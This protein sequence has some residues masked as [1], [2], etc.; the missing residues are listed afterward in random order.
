MPAIGCQLCCVAV[1]HMRAAG[2]W[3]QAWHT[4]SVLPA[5]S[6]AV[7]CLALLL[8]LSCCNTQSSVF[9]NFIIEKDPVDEASVELPCTSLH[10]L[11]T[12]RLY[13]IDVS[14]EGVTDDTTH[15]PFPSLT[16]LKAYESQYVNPYLHML[17]SLKQLSLSRHRLP[18]RQPYEDGHSTHTADTPARGVDR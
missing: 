12:L 9:S 6:N 4:A 2:Q 17:T 15:N 1:A 11:R 8:R 3:Q 10:K 13:N 14:F 18:N 16:S 7:P 5:L